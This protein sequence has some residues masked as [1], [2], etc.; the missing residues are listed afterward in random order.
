MV[1]SQ[2]T[3]GAELPVTVAPFHSKMYNV[4]RHLY[5]PNALAV[6]RV[7]RRWSYATYYSH[8]DEQVR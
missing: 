5:D 3:R 8:N 2:F 7:T 1:G 4:K 6:R